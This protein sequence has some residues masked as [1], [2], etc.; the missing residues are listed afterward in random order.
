MT[1]SITE[2]SSPRKDLFYSFAKKTTNS[3]LK[4][5]LKENRVSQET[6]VSEGD[7]ICDSSLMGQEE[8]SKNVLLAE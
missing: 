3:P 6:R 2:G 8:K 1:N 7:S 4:P 5:I